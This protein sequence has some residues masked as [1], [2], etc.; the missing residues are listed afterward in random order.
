MPDEKYISRLIKFHTSSQVEQRGRS[1]FKQNAV[2]FDDY[3]EKNDKYLFTVTGSKQYKVA[4]KG[5]ENKDP[6]FSCTCPFDWGRMCKHTVA[7]LMYISG[8]KKQDLQKNTSLPGQ[9]KYREKGEPVYLENYKNITESS[10]RNLSSYIVFDNAT[11]YSNLEITDFLIIGKSLVFKVTK[12]NYYS[13]NE[14]TV[15]FTLENNKLR[16]DT[17]EG[18]KVL[19]DFLKQSEVFVLLQLVYNNQGGLFNSF[20][21]TNTFEAIKAKTVEK[22]GLDKD[23][24]DDFFEFRYIADQ[25]VAVVKKDTAYGLLPVNGE[26]DNILSLFDKIN[27]FSSD[28]FLTTKIKKAKITAWD[29]FW[30]FQISMFMN[31]DILFFRPNTTKPEPNSCHQ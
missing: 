14:Y 20:F 6:D 1:L 22:Y 9:K 4:I 12:D 11:S 31:T 2:M 10:I 19:K 5:L 21:H 17:T 13:E 15:S 7:A 30:I 3:D 8:L 27:N 26:N 29:L 18:Y 23:E 24:F 25:G 16:I 28:N